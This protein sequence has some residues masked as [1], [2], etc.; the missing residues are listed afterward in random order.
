MSWPELQIEH[1]VVAVTIGWLAL[2][3]FCWG[4]GQRLTAH[5]SHR[6]HAWNW[7]AGAALLG[8][9]QFIAWLG[10][11]Q[12]RLDSWPQWARAVIAAFTTA[13]GI[14]AALA[15]WAWTG[16]PLSRAGGWCV[17]L[18]AAL[19]TSEFVIVAPVL[20]GLGW[21]ALAMVF[22]LTNISGLPRGSRI[23][24][25]VAFAA[26]AVAES[27]T[28]DLTQLILRL[29]SELPPQWGSREFVTLA[30]TAG[31]ALIAGLS[32]WLAD[33][34]RRWRNLVAGVSVASI[35]V[36]LGWH[37][38][39]TRAEK[40]TQAWSDLENAAA[41]L[42][43]TVAML[44]LDS[45]DVRRPEYTELVARLNSFEHSASQPAHLWLWAVRDRTV[46]HVADTASL[47]SQIGAPVTPPGYR[48]PQLHNFVLR[49]AR[50][51]RFE[52]GPFFVAGARRVGLHVP[53][54][55]TADSVPLA[56]L[57]LSMPFSKWAQTFS[58]PRASAIIG[59]LLIG[60]LV[61]LVLAGQSWLEAARKLHGL[62]VEA[63]ASARAKNEMAGLVSHELRTP[64]QVVL[65]HLE[66]LA[67]TPHAPATERTLKIIEGQC[68]QLLGLVNDTLDLCALEAGQL[69]VRPVRFS[70]AVLAQVTVDDLLPLATERGLVFDLILQPGLPPLVEADA[71]RIRQILTNL[72]ANAL[73][74]TPKGFV[75]LSVE[76][77]NTPENRLVFTVADSGPGLPESV[78]ARLGTAFQTG[79]SKQG[80]GLG[81]AIVRRLC[82]HLGGEFSVVNAA[83]GGCIA[84]VR[85]PAPQAVPD[86]PRFG[87]KS[88]VVPD[89]PVLDGMRIVL[90]EDNTLVRELIASH[91]RSL[92]AEVEAVSDGAAALFSCRT[93]PPHAVLFDLAMPGMDGRTAA[94]ALRQSA[95]DSPVP[96]LIVGLSAEAISEDEARAAGFDRFFVKPVAL[97]ELAAVFAPSTPSLPPADLSA[98]RLRRL[99]IGEAPGQLSTIHAAVS[100]DDRSE[101]VR[102]AHYLQSSAYALSDEPLRA[103]C[104]TLRQCA[105]SPVSATT[106]VEALRGVEI[107]IARIVSARE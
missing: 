94:R 54:R 48:Y 76:V 21:A 19:L 1:L 17:L 61:G 65:G 20:S 41:A 24:L 53:L 38:A 101:I 75:H 39:Q 81:L 12:L 102:L 82:T 25:G 89:A 84:T 16:R 34:P 98:S 51:E 26:L 27:A 78:L 4:C 52:S 5:G 68:R 10:L 30:L 86:A 106:T 80:T 92:G 57:Q 18:G 31:L 63:D 45:N 99:F 22:F 33:Q 90:A 43:S 9:L 29:P 50:G 46:V 91:L 44:N 97:A 11:I 87:S 67:A 6:D 66:V 73:K 3:W 100:R 8:A 32:L 105:E 23:S 36:L 62:A 15:A 14:T 28:P 79:P 2:A 104:S 74:Y 69:P 64:L 72:L 95:A 71:A 42:A 83:T 58:D 103:A 56:W 40:R 77:E 37:G 93:N 49:A 88:P 85:L 47:G 13:H 60:A 59:A 55:T 107:E 35:V 7:L 70:P 96:K